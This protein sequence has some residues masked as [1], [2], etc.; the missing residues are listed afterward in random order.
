M[1][2]IRPVVI[3]AAVLSVASGCSSLPSPTSAT[4]APPPDNPVA[5]ID[6]DL[7]KRGYT[8]ATFRGQRVYCRKEALTGSNL[9]TRVCLTA[10]QIEDEERA[11]KDVLT[12]SRPAGCEPSK[13]GCD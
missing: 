6:L 12:G 9:R 1:K 11:A 4:H 5:V 2:A 7:R 3:G 8:P 10:K 13:Y